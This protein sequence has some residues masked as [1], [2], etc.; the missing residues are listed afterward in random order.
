MLI[1]PK[2]AEN[3]SCDETRPCLDAHEAASLAR[4]QG[5]QGQILPRGGCR[6]YSF[7]RIKQTGGYHPYATDK[8]ESIAAGSDGS[9]VVTVKQQGI[10]FAVRAEFPYYRKSHCVNIP[11]WRRHRPSSHHTPIS[12]DKV[13]LEINSEL[14][15]G[16]NPI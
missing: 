9:V 8:V 12:G 6:T 5:L 16:S 15:E 13:T 2:L 11:L 10:A 7:E 4:W 3:W 1:T 14:V